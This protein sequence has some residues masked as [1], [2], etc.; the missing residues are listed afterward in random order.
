MLAQLDIYLEI[1]EP[2]PPQLHT[3]NKNIFRADCRYT[4]G[5]TIRFKMKTPGEY[6][7]DLRVGTDVL[8]R[9]QKALGIKGKFDILDEIKNGSVFQSKVTIN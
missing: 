9:T 3:L 6:L 4:K 2:R 8:D 1:N 5:K 7:C